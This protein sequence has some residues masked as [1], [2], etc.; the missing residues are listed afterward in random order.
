MIECLPG[1]RNLLELD[2]DAGRAKAGIAVV[3]TLLP[4]FWMPCGALTW[5]FIQ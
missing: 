1:S 5:L 4:W 2:E 3:T